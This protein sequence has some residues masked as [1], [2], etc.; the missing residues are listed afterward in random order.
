MVSL[1]LCLL[2][3]MLPLLPLLK[4]RT[5]IKVRIVSSTA[6]NIANVFEKSIEKASTNIAKLTEA[7]TEGDAITCLGVVELEGMDLDFMQLIRVAMYFGN[8]PHQLRT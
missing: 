3:P 7:I 2:T 6:A 5:N 4:Y 1:I 8:K